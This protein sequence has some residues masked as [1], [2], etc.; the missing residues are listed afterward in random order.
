MAMLGGA[1]VVEMVPM[2]TCPPSGVV[3]TIICC[4]SGV[5][6]TFWPPAVV[7]IEDP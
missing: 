1:A 7:E 2:M 5:V 3:L 4:P 6:T